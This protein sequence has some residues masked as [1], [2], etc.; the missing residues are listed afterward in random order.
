MTRKKLLFA[1]LLLLLLGWLCKDGLIERWRF[2]GFEPAK[3]K[4][5]PK[6][7]RY[8][9]ACYLV[10]K[11]WLRDKSRTEVLELL[12]KPDIGNSNPEESTML[13]YNLG[14]ERGSLFRV[15][16][17]WLEFSVDGA[18]ARVISARIRPD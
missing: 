6:Q 3:W 12:G 5:A 17:D 7:D 14:P 1:T 10:D 11:E 8:F 2:Y 18:S 15:D 16:D 13:L 9:M 4:V